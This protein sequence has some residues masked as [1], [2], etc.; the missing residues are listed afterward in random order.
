[1]I[2]A[3]KIKL[4]PNKPQTVALNKACG[5]ARF[6]YN[7][8]LVKWKEYY[9][10]SKVDESLPKPNSNLIKKE[11]NRV[12]EKEFPWIYDSPKDANQQAFSNLGNAFSK[13]F[14][15][16]PGYPRLKKKGNKDS[17]Y[18]SNDKFKLLEGKI[19]VPLIGNIE[20]A[21]NLRFHGGVKSATISR[22]ADEW[23]V[24]ISVEMADE[25][26]KKQ[27][28]GNGAVG[29]DFGVKNVLVDSN[30]TKINSPKPLKK[31]LK[32]LKRQQR[33]LSRR[34]KGSKNRE[35]QRN[36]VSKIH[37]KIADSRLDF[38]HK[39]TSKYC[40]ENQTIIV[41]DLTVN[42]WAKMFGKNAIDNS[43]GEYFRQ[44]DYKKLIYNNTLH[45]INKWYPS[46]KTC[47]SCKNVKDRIFLDERTYDCH[48]CGY[49][50]DRDI[51]AA[52]NILT[53]GL[54]GI[55]ACG[56]STSGP[57]HSGGIKL[58]ERNKNFSSV[59]IHIFTH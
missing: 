40:S 20:L 2:L 11:F 42:G 56:H 59:E 18:L 10:K 4:Y 22:T 9:E 50:E 16:G 15:G 12:K 33:I 5:C 30:G 28:V 25:D 13:F 17:F 32:R 45:R 34:K 44:L 31:Y 19:K 39:T 47:Y 8:G 58:G 57:T 43:V 51:N 53:V 46:S 21:E 23:F 29:I 54:T 27:R 3:H 6:A 41:E 1:M 38:I 14:K 49:M 7:W 37:K 48:V 36:K 24:S 55:N 35:K 52:K 26:A